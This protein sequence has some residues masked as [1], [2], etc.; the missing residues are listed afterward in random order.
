MPEADVELISEI[1]TL[2]DAIDNEISLLARVT[3]QM[4]QDL[5]SRATEDMVRWLDKWEPFP[6][7]ELPDY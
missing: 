2:L 1:D 3:S 4:N 7:M 5:D 6:A